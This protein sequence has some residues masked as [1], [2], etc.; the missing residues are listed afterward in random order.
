MDVETFRRLL[1]PTGQTLLTQVSERAG[2]ESD[3]ALGSRL[4][5]YHDPALVAAAVTQNHLRG[6][7]VRKFGTDAAR[8]Y[9]THDGLEQATRGRVADYRAQRLRALG[10]TTVVDLGCGIG[11]DLVAFARAGMSVRGVDIDPVRAQIAQANLEALGLSGTVEAGDATKADVA[12]D[13]VV[14]CDPA[15]RSARGR[16]FRLNGLVPSWDFVTEQLSGRGLAKV[17][18]GVAHDDIPEGVRAEWI[19]DGGDL[20][21]CCLWGK[22]LAPVSSSTG[23]GLLRATLLPSG[24]TMTGSGVIPDDG[25]VGRFLY[26]PD[27]AVIRAGL[28]ADLAEQI[29]GWLPDKQ[30]AWISTDE[31]VATPFAH[32]FTVVDEIPFRTKQMRVALQERD[33]GPLTI[34]KRGVQQS[35]EDVIAKLKLTGSQAATVVLTRVQGSGKAFLVEPH[36]R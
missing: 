30:I 18:P 15:R 3:Y 8:M 10:A 25:P 17:M 35:P 28:V 21:E 32:G 12:D 23:D 13:E 27:D 24:E 1:T 14:F 36:A 16:I 33:I 5:R 11:A 34:K 9:F 31:Q 7:A 6:L 29:G 22:G 4:R 19:S 2:V 20:V 26:E